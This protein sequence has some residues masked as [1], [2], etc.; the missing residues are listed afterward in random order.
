MVGGGKGRGG[1]GGGD[2][3]FKIGFSELFSFI[4]NY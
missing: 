4:N 3:T 1:G 2:E